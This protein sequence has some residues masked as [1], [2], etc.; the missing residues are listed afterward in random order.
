MIAI[1]MYDKLGNVL[2]IGTCND[3]GAFR[4]KRKVDH[5]DDSSSEQKTALKKHLQ[6]IPVI[7]DH[8]NR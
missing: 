8:D 2:W 6:L 1:K 4:V 7:Y 3:V 5:R